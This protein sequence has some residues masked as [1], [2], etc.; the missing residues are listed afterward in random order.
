MRA[1]TH[2]T[3]FSRNATLKPGFS[4]SAKVHADQVEVVRVTHHPD[5][6]QECAL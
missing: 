3:T 2:I 4:A 5:T 6:M 1:A